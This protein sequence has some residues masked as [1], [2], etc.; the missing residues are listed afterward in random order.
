MTNP[1]IEAATQPFI[2]LREL[3]ELNLLIDFDCSASVIGNLMDS[4]GQVLIALMPWL[5]A[6]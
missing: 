2:M 6:L 1:P 3:T 5:I 4:P